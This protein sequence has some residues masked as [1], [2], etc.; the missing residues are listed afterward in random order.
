M[1]CRVPPPNQLCGV[2]STSASQSE[3]SEDAP[4]FNKP[5]NVSDC[6]WKVG[7]GWVAWREGS[8]YMMTQTIGYLMIR[9]YKTQTRLN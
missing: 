5:D 4:D 1:Y 3:V 8:V 6:H 2:P 7:R 9:L